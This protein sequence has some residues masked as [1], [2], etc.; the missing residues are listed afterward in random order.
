MAICAA[1][2][3]DGATV[4]Q[5]ADEYSLSDNRIRQILARALVYRWKVPA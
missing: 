4:Q 5:L 2:D 1:Y 3:Q